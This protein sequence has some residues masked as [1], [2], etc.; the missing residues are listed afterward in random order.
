MKEKILEL[1]NQGKTYDEIQN[2]L[3]CS[4]S[5]ISYYCGEGQKDKAYNRVK[6]KRED[7][8]YEKIDRFKSRNTNLK[9]RDFQR[10]DGSNKLTNQQ[11]KNFTVEEAKKKIG[12]NP[13]CYLTGQK[14]DLNNPKEYHLDHVLP[15]EKGGKNTLDNMDLLKS[16]INKMKS[17]LTI[18][19]LINNCVL[20]LSHNGYE[21][22]KL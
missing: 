6:K 2:I 17:N 4:K 13:I 1:R 20:I 14:I 16:E 11:E 21:V 15:V 22:K 7:K 9:F 10:R 12:E 18:E 3:G 19:E 8:F 5:T